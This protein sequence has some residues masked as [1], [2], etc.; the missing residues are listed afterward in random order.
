MVEKDDMT[1]LFAPEV[2]VFLEHALENIPITDRCPHQLDT[3]ARHRLLEADIT[4]HRGHNCPA[5]QQIPFLE[6]QR[7]R[8]QDLITVHDLPIL[9]NKHRAVG[10]AVVCDPESRA[11]GLHRF[12]NQARV[13]GA[14]F[15]VD[16]GAVGVATSDRDPSSQFPVDMRRD[17]VGSP[18]S[19]IHHDRHAFK[20]KAFGE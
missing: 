6:I 8:S 5:R 11:L 15:P 3:R 16:V 10:I 7:Q 2:I 19:A 12:L 1:R 4:H 14:A 18:V 17:F 13:N 20:I 9:R